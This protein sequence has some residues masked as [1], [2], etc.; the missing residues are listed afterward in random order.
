MAGGA[1][2]GAH[3]NEGG[4]VAGSALSAG[5]AICCCVIGIPVIFAGIIMVVVAEEG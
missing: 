5:L 4:I 3:N 1:G 2:S